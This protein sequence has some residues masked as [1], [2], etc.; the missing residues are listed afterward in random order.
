MA[1][2]IRSIR[3]EVPVDENG[4]PVFVGIEAGEIK[5]FI[6]STQLY[7]PVT[8]DE[9]GNKI[10]VVAVK[11]A[12]GGNSVLELFAIVTELPEMGDPNKIYLVPVESD[13]EEVN[14][15]TE[16]IFVNDTWE[17]IGTVTTDTTIDLDNY[18][19]KSEVDT[20]LDVVRTATSYNNA[21]TI[22]LANPTKIVTYPEP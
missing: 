11:N 9:N 2:S 14:Q 13:G 18:Y 6:R 1:D 15:F 8:E 10:P 12:N 17:P 16:Y 21:M 19:T 3:L 4:I 20:L 7:V 22:S 5:N